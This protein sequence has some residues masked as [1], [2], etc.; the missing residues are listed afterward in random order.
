MLVPVSQDTNF[1]CLVL[2]EVKAIQ[3]SVLQ[4]QKVVIQT[5]LGDANFVGRLFKRLSSL[6]VQVSP[7]LDLLDALSDLAFLGPPRPLACRLVLPLH[8]GFDVVVF[9]SVSNLEHHHKLGIHL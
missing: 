6:V 5:L 1:V 4:L 2:V 8:Q 7:L 9:R 3:L